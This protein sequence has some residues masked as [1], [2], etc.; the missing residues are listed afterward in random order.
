MA[1]LDGKITIG[2]DYRPV[3]CYE[4][5]DKTSMFIVK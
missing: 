3:Y 4:I 1:V 5:E 2:I